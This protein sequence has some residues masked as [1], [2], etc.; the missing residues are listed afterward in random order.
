VHSRRVYPYTIIFFLG[1][2]LNSALGSGFIVAPT[3]PAAGPPEAIAVADFNLDGH[4]DLAIGDANFSTGSVDI[5][6]GNGDGTFQLPLSFNVIGSS[7]V[8]VGDFNHDG[9]GP[10]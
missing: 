3:F 1:C 4:L 7:Y 2:A 5:L 10:I 9:C 6:L 8:A